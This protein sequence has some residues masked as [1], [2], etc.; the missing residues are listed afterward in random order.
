M[1]GPP[2]SRDT[3]S[4]FLDFASRRNKKFGVRVVGVKEGIAYP[5]LLP[6]SC[7]DRTNLISSRFSLRAQLSQPWTT[8]SRTYMARHRRDFIKWTRGPGKLLKEPRPD[9][10]NY[11]E[12]KDSKGN[13]LKR[14]FPLNPEFKSEAVLDDK[15]REMI[16]EEVMRKGKTIKQVSAELGVDITRVAAIVRLKEVEKD[17][18]SKGKKLATPYCKAI[19]S[20]VPTKSFKSAEQQ[21]V[22]FEPINELHIHASTM[23]QI[24]WP[25]SESRHFTRADAAKAFHKDMLPADERVP[26]PELLQM[27]KSLLEGKSVWEAKA[28]FMDA[29]EKSERNAAE[30]QM[31]RAMAEDSATRKFNTERFEF[32]FKEFNSEDVGRDG[33][34]KKAVGWKYGM[35]SYDRMKGAIKIPTKV[36]QIGWS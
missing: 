7:Q 26:H 29:A 30:R 9:Q 8:Q 19:L 2:R 36:P 33:R 13:M 16:W 28:E 18:I 5:A 21:N 25:T 4:G 22:P 1:A 23:K 20:M 3:V 31:R 27:E 6:S 24:F 15:A 34:R 35:P 12:T 11:L 14:P 17:W 32:R 10:T